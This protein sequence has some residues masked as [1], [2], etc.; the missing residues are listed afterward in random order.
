M[1]SKY[2]ESYWLIFFIQGVI[3]LLYGLF[4][5][6]TNISDPKLLSAISAG[7]LF[8]LGL[9]ELFNLFSRRRRRQN[10]FFVLF[11]SILQIALAGA[12]IYALNLNPI[13]TLAILSGYTLSR[14]LFEIF[15]S[16]KALTDA[17]DRFIWSVCGIIGTVIGVVIFNSGHFANPVAF[18]QFFGS[19]MMVFGLTNLVYSIHNR[20]RLATV[21]TDRTKLE[22]KCQN[23]IKSKK[24][25]KSKQTKTTKTKA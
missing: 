20:N 25:K 1:K 24:A 10:W 14:G 5:L 13:Y 11:I 8:L 6:F 2:I 7:V 18:I 4:A 9:V 16:F 21:A 23:F 15:L 19:Y 22:L 17:T 3:A 12:L